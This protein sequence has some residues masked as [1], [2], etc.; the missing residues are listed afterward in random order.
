MAIVIPTFKPLV[1]GALPCVQ[2]QK[3]GLLLAE[4]DVHFS[5]S[6]QK[7]AY[8]N[9]PDTYMSCA[10]FL[11]ETVLNPTHV[12]QSPHHAENGF[13]IVREIKEEGL[14]LL[15]ALLLKPTNRG[16]YQVTSTYPID[17]NKLDRRV[18]KNFLFV[19]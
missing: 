14:I 2:L 4:G 17:A 12:G 19:V 18:R 5:I 16:V 1:L 8:R 10:P 13:E 11:S 3:A 15:V 6:A 9:H 7:H